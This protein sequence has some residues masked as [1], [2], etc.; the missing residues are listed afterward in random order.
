MDFGVTIPQA[1]LGFTTLDLRLSNDVN[2]RSQ[3]LLLLPAY[4]A[5]L[6]ACFL[7]ICVVLPPRNLFKRVQ[8][9]VSD[10]QI[11]IGIGEIWA[12][13]LARVVGCLALV[14]VSISATYDELQE[15]KKAPPV[16]PSDF[17][18]WTRL[19]LLNGPYVYA[20]SLSLPTLSPKHYRQNLVRHANLVLFAAFVVYACRDLLPL[21]TFTLSPLDHGP[22]MAAKIALVS[23]TGVVVPLF[24]PRLYIPVD[25]KNPQAVI[26]PEQTASIISFA[27]YFFLDQITLSAY[28]QSGLPEEELYALCDTDRAIYLKERSFKH[29][30]VF[31]GAKQRY[32]FFGLM[33]IFWKEFCVLTVLIVF[34]SLANYSGPFAMNR[35][36]EYI[37]TRD[38]VDGHIM[39]PWVW[40]ALVG[41]G[42][43]YGS[44]AFQLYIFINTRTLVRTESIVTQLVLAH[45]LRIRVKAETS[46]EQKKDPIS[47]S[48]AST[49]SR[50]DRE[51]V[52]AE[53]D[54]SSSQQDETEST[55]VQ[56]SSASAKSTKSTGTGSLKKPA[57]R[58][59]EEKKAQGSMVGKINNLVTTDLYVS[60]YF[61]P[62][63][64]NPF[65]C[66]ERSCDCFVPV[67][68]RDFLVL[69]VYNPVQIML[70]IYFLYVLLDWA[71]W[72]G[73]ASI[74]LLAPL[75][76]YMAKL[77]QN[78]QKERLKRTDER[79]SS[80]SEAVNVLRMVKLFGWETKMNKRIVDKR[81]TEL[82]WI[83][84]RR[85]LDLAS[86]LVNFLIPVCYHDGGDIWN[87]CKF[88]VLC[89]YHHETET[90]QTL[91]M[92]QPLTASK[93][94]SSMTIF[95]FLRDNIAM[96]TG[97]I[98]N[99]MTG[100][101]SLDRVDDFLKKTELLDTYNTKDILVLPTD[102]ASHA[103]IGFRNATFSWATE[104]DEQHSR[105]R[106]QFRLKIADEVLFKRGKINLVVG[107]TG[108]G[109]TSLLMALLGE[110]HFIP[111]SPTSWFNL[112][113]DGGVAYAAQ[114]SWVLNETIR[115]NI[116]FDTPYDKE[117]YAKVLYQCAL[118]Q[119]LVL[120]H[121]GDQTE[122]GEKGLTLSGG[123]K[124][125]L[126]LAR[127]V[128]SKA[129]ILLLDDV[130]AALDV[131]TAQHIV[132]NL[133]AGDLIENRTVILVTHN[134]ALTKP[135][136]DFIVTFDADGCIQAQGTVSEI[137]K[138]ASV[139]AQ[140]H[141]EQRNIHK[142]QQVV[143]LKMPG[144][145]KPNLTDGKL[146]LA[147]EIQV[148]HV[149][150]SALKMYLVG[151]GGKH[152]V[153]FFVFFYS[154][155]FINQAL[156]TLRTWMLGWWAKQYDDRPA[157]EVDIVLNLSLFSAHLLL[158]LHPL[159]RWLL[160]L[161]SWCLDNYEHQRWLDITPVSRIIARVTNDIRAV[162]DAIPNQ[163]WPLTSLL[164]SMV[165][166]F[167][168][169][170]LYA[171]VFF[172]PGVAIGAVG[173]W[174]GQIYI[175]GQLPV[176]RL[177]S[178]TRAPVVA[179]FGAAISGLVSIRA[180]GAEEKFKQESLI[181]IDRYT[182]AARNFYNLNRSVLTGVLQLS[183]AHRGH[184]MIR[185]VSIRV[186]ILGAL[187]SAGLAAYLV[188]IKPASAGD[189][190]FLINMAVTFTQMLLWVVRFLNQFEVEGNSLERIQSY[191]EIDHEKPATLEGKPPAY[192]PSS[193]ELVVE[194][195]TARYSEDGP[196]VL[197]GIT[198]H[199][200]AGERIGIV[201]RT[202]SGKSSLTLSLLRC[203]PTEGSVRYD[204]LETSSMNLDALRTSI[205]IIPQVPELLSGTLRSNLDPFGQYDDAEL[206]YAL[207]AAGLFSLQSETD[208]GRIT[209]DSTI[210]AG[211]SNLSVG[212]RQIFAL[213][214]AIVRKSKILILDE[215][216]LLR[217]L[218]TKRVTRALVIEVVVSSLLADSIIQASLR[219]E[220]SKDVSLLTVAHRLQTIMDADKIL[221]LDAGNIVEFDSP[222]ELLKIRGGK[223]RAL[224]E[225]SG[226]RD[227]L[228]AM[229]G[230]TRSKE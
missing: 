9:D 67:E 34:R 150:A 96:I 122:V 224:V 105:S 97:W 88:I 74:I 176:K 139:A 19:A 170:V 132:E 167:G 117:R 33:R 183:F 168:S 11:R 54:A 205:T 207:R 153:M 184:V 5:A 131:H 109:K 220:L 65:V 187:F 127:A 12:W 142:Q 52:A 51:T 28:R 213:A 178:N 116:T 215:G 219:R 163:L 53:D 10:T 106:R 157:N 22:K 161:S 47:S 58:P 6:S 39:R 160:F 203:I 192:W 108:S 164:V 197:K 230:A 41:L 69:L 128:Y 182:R 81:D 120:F 194:N 138:R 155:L 136:A 71:V 135:I 209:L 101:V 195:L 42:P 126:T 166:R 137:T 148:G 208:E 111:S 29:L 3:H 2:S 1:V 206:N 78:I 181:K 146:I 73:V 175:A 75:P 211:G 91:I 172:F 70:G 92:G 80:V 24:T 85:L 61:W 119:D 149:N 222:K 123:Q 134:I 36:L 177:M 112:P 14:G 63:L 98:N 76:G 225:E 48:D 191:I 84:R 100:K 227:A 37:E 4:I 99:L 46:N 32:L 72:V 188:Y 210:A 133:F 110:M 16:G 198:F 21:A 214:R 156:T 104:D 217:Q 40:I 103:Q 186:D 89:S 94:F 159:L 13:R 87:L 200:K 44:L 141:E 165:V 193:G 113:R 190:G 26:N 174:I 218:T 179:H 23:F 77:V 56:P 15:D 185:W 130:L 82:V 107:P 50:T 90:V 145:T 201:G 86:N 169:I 199:V 64:V 125:R 38:Q 30:E 229:A 129:E 196:A 35:L 20:L 60:H 79:V 212:Q 228:Y 121:A 221:V 216:I 102:P 8:T 118:E 93:V 204:G 154:G 66:R 143:D 151:M 68:S 180:F 27:L 202:G 173:A 62:I 226:D 31:S 114:E 45:S 162:D 59:G 7:L 124:A 171:P 49:S 55:A 25:P 18:W 189:A 158:H 57:E 83:R 95:D 115:D 144:D 17:E 223:L 147:E 152:P 140:I 43:I